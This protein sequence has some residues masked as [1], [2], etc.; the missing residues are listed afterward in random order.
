MSRGTNLRFYAYT[1]A[2]WLNLL[3]KT[4]SVWI[5]KM[6]NK[7]LIPLLVSAVAKRNKKAFPLHNIYDAENACKAL[8][9]RSCYCWKF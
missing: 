2:G 4:C 8:K 6:S 5:S 7:R 9:T 3:C 1:I